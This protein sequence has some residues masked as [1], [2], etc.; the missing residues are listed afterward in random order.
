MEYFWETTGSIPKGQ[1]FTL[2]SPTHIFWL[3]LFLVTATVLPYT[4]RRLGETGRQRMRLTVASLIFAD[5]LAK[6]VMLLATGLF[7]KNYLP[8]QLCTINIFIIAIHLVKPSKTL[9][10]FLYAICLP[11][12]LLAIICPS[13]TKLPLLNFMHIHSSSIHILLAVYPLMLL[14]GGEVAPRFREAWKFLLILLCLAV[15]AVITNL[16]LGTNYMFLAK[17]DAAILPIFETIFGNHLF[18]FPIILA[19]LWGAMFAPFEILLR[20]KNEKTVSAD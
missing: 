4:Y 6:W 16:T 13:W 1:G 14:V 9:A 20:R 18:G 10:N 2:F 3:C 12:A 15:P 7:T 8:F 19:V 11:G 17:P 5:E